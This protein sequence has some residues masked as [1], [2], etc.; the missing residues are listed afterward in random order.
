MAPVRRTP[1]ATVALRASLLD[2]A[3]EVVRRDGAKAF[4]MRAL[5][6]EAGCALGL[7]YK[8]FGGRAEL[9]TDLLDAYFH[10]LVAAFD[11]VVATAG[12]ATVAANLDRF[13][14][15]L[16][17]SDPEIMKLADVPVDPV[18]SGHLDRSAQSSG[19]VTGL[20]TT[21]S[22]YLAAEKE[23]G[24]IDD[25]VDVDAIGFLVTGAIHNLLVSG[26]SYP[27]PDRNQIRGH[28][29]ALARLLH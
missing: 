18:L 15:V 10:R 17:T 11:D 26:E 12:T 4:T 6:A 28:L 22:R 24:R 3:L 19:F 8:V 14:D 16:L 20:A 9:V 29:S 23:L 27:R 21:V 7:P 13:A 1:D 2:H 5:A 25:E